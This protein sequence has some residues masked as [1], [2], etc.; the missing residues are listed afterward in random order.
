MPGYFE[1]GEESTSNVVDEKEGL[2]FAEDLPAD[3]PRPLHGPN[4]YP[5][6]EDAPGLR[7]LV[8]EWQARTPS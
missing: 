1:V 5:S 8:I 6:K 4:L 2:Y 7:E 3:D